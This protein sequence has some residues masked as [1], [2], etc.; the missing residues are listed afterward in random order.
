M[1]RLAGVSDE[2][3]QLVSNSIVW[4]N[5]LSWDPAKYGDIEHIK[6]YR[7][8]GIKVIALSIAFRNIEGIEIVVRRIAKLYD[9]IKKHAD[10]V[11]LCK[12]VAD[13][14]RAKEEGKAAVFLSFQ[15]TIPFEENLTLIGF[16]YE[17]GVRHASLAYN[18]R[19]SVGDGCAEPGNA[20]LSLFGRDV[21]REMNRVGM[22]V[23]GAHS[24]HRTTMEAMEICKAPFT[25]SHTNI[26]AIHPHYRNIKDDQ[27]RACA[28][29][30]GVIGITGCGEYL[31]EIEPRAETMF[32]HIDYVA[33]MVGAQHVGIGF[34]YVKDYRGFYETA[35]IPRKNVWPLPPGGER[36]YCKFL[37]PEKLLDVVELLF[38]H[39]YEEEDVK[40]F[41]GENFLRLAKEAWK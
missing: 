29:T 23:D 15:E 3:V 33:Q 24:G 34:D 40:G 31:G 16:F 10:I 36:Q 6:R 13:I 1:K 5:S 38:Q 39:G 21:V 17:L 35:V 37:E 22:V 41:L 30:G 20:G 32:K 28:K 8:I 9:E 18:I 7:S 2:H 25:F 19:N 11:V 27:I 4:D 26:H 12:S 14:M